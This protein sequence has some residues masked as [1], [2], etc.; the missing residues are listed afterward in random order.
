DLDLSADIAL[1]HQAIGRLQQMDNPNAALKSLQEAA[2]I[3][4]TAIPQSQ[5]KLV[6]LHAFASIHNDIGVVYVRKHEPLE[7]MS[8]YTAALKL[9]RQLVN[10]NRDHPKSPQLKYDLANQLTRMGILQGDIGLSIEPLK[11]HR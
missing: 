9:Q 10:E 1:H 2:G 7:A 8:Y 5:N 11:L 4:R 3:L 6:L